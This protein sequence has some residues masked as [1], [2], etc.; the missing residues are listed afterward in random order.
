MLYTVGEYMEKLVCDPQKVIN[1][2]H[3]IAG[4]IEAVEKMYRD[5]RPCSEI[6]QQIVAARSSLGSLAK[7]I[8]SDE[9]NGCL[10]SE[11]SSASVNKLVSQ[12]IDI[13]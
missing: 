4:Q 2:T 3:R 5:K 7:Q 9:V 12:L 10:P 13:S 6:I 8:L 1:H 11:S